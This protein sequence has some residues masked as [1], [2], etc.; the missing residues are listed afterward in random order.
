MRRTALLAVFF[1]FAIWGCAS[2]D[3]PTP[4]TVARGQFNGVRWEFAIFQRDGKPCVE[5]K[6]EGGTRPGITE[7]CS[8]TKAAGYWEEPV[9][10]PAVRGQARGAVLFLRMNPRVGSVNLQLAV[11][12]H[13]NGS[14]WIHVDSQR[15]DSAT[16]EAAGFD[17]P[18]GF[19]VAEVN[20]VL[21]GRNQVCVRRAVV[22]DHSGKQLE[23]SPLTICG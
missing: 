12:T 10:Q 6:A 11:A 20:G 17:K 23:R 3:A 22:F 15:V 21:I 5:A 18:L 19:G 1:A 4:Q 9:V 7:S 8:L 13:K 16:Q 14:R 2:A